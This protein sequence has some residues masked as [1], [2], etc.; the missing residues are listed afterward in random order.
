M[1]LIEISYRATSIT[2]SVTLLLHKA[3]SGGNVGENS[4]CILLT[5]RN[6]HKHLPAE[7]MQ[8]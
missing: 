1:Y 8:R 5:D 3:E 2:F 6:Y 4:D 7:I